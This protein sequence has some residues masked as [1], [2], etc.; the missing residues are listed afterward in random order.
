MEELV[1]SAQEG[2]RRALEELVTSIQ[3]KIYRLALH[4]LWHPEDARDAAQEILVR[5]V[6]RLSSFRGESSFETWAYRVA[7]NWLLNARKQRMELQPLSFDDFAADLEAGAC[8]PEVENAL[9][10]EEVRVGCTLGMLLCLD[11]PHRLAFILGEILELDHSE[12][13]SVLEITPAAFRK[14]LS[15]ARRAVIE[16]TRARCGMVNPDN[17]CRC[18]LRVTP[19]LAMKRV[20]RD[21][22]LFAHDAERARRFPEVL[23]EIR[24]L[25]E[26]QRAV[27]LF[28]SQPQPDVD[29][30]A[31][32][33]NL[34]AGL[35]SAS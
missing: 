15:R 35:R 21:H 16:F 23:A 24:R 29:L 26:T 7:T 19:A 4:M 11:R 9:L 6:T 2:D 5:I 25:D 31:F 13:A 14:R 33:R 34:T 17:A 10:F 1:R 28:R 32:V 27:A 18:R 8:E 20:D 12:A 30:V 3:Q 22:L